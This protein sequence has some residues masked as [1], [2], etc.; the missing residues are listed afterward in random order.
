[1]SWG[2]RDSDCP[3]DQWF[4]EFEI[5]NGKFQSPIDIKTGNYKIFHFFYFYLILHPVLY[6][7]LNQKCTYMYCI[8][9]QPTESVVFLSLEFLLEILH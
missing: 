8:D 4:K 6:S 3:P 7:L 5:A 1:M 9:L 2:Y